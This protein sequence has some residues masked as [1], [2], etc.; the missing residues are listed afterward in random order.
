V[1]KAQQGSFAKDTPEGLLLRRHKSESAQVAG[2]LWFMGCQQQQIALVLTHKIRHTLHEIM[3]HLGLINSRVIQDNHTANLCLAQIRRL[4]PLGQGMRVFNLKL[5]R[6]RY[7][8]PQ[9]SDHVPRSVKRAHNVG[10]GIQAIAHQEP[11]ARHATR[12]LEAQTKSIAL[13]KGPFF[14]KAK[15][16]M[17]KSPIALE[18]TRGS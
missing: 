18:V 3:D 12:W 1:Q 6:I 2:R 14:L 13:I 9:S 16:M 5:G 11:V 4:K 8:Q 15:H 7:K 17:A 10:D